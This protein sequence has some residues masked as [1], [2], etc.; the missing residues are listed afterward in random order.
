MRVGCA[1]VRRVAKGEEGEE[2]EGMELKQQVSVEERRLAWGERRLA[3][4]EW[5]LGRRSRGRL[6]RLVMRVEA[7][8]WREDVWWRVGDRRVGWWID[9]SALLLSETP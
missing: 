6:V 1:S 8:A 4:G 2:G 7:R 5:P 9:W 3:W